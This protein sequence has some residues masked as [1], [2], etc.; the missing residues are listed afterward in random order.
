M[1]LCAAIAALLI[2]GCGDDG[3]GAN[4]LAVTLDLIPPGDMV[5]LKP[6]CDVF[7]NKFCRA[8]QRCTVGTQNGTPRDI[9]VPLSATPLPLGAV[10]A[11]VD[12]GSG[13]IGDDC[14][15]G[16]ICLDFPGDGPHCKKPCYVRGQCAAGEACVLL[17]PTSTPHT[18]PD[19]GVETLRACAH[20]DGCDPVAQTVCSGGRHCWLSPV[21]DVGRVGIC[22][23]DLV[24]GMNGASCTAQATCAPG[25]RCDGLQFCR[26]YCYFDAP[27]GGVAAGVGGC[28]ASEGVCDRFSFSGP[29]Y[30]ICGVN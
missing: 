20:D 19:A 13:R 26:R 6:E 30:G 3:L 27:D 21:D 29:I 11:P 1:R 17:T 18:D 12:E 16:L 14:D 24:P 5:V 28:P 4:D 2:A 10:C 7:A 23:M 15:A 9:C 8:G 25:F 22:L